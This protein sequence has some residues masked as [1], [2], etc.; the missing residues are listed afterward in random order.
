MGSLKDLKE[1]FFSYKFEYRV[2]FFIAL[3]CLTSIPILRVSTETLNNPGTYVAIS[4]FILF[5]L[6]TIAVTIYE[7]KILEREIDMEEE[8]SMIDYVPKD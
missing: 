1:K 3:T 7:K 8:P 6:M 4:F 2:G 5:N